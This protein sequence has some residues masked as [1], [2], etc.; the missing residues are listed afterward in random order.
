MVSGQWIVL[1]HFQSR[2]SAPLMNRSVGFA[3]LHIEI[4]KLNNSARDGWFAG[5]CHGDGDGTCRSRSA[6]TATPSASSREQ[7]RLLQIDG[8]GELG[9]DS[10]KSQGGTLR[11]GMAGAALTI[12]VEE[13]FA[14]GDIAGDL[15]NPG[16][17]ALECVVNPLREEMGEVG[18]LGGGQIGAA[19]LTLQRMSLPEKRAEIGT[20]VVFQDY[21]GPDQ[22]GAGFAATG[23]GTMTIHTLSGVQ[24]TSAVGGGRVGHS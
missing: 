10:E 16:G 19:L 23:R 6:A 9:A 11:E 7:H 8:V 15:V 5:R 24:S 20:C 1:N 12:A 14:R 13:S 17:P 18:H 4:V 21:I 3:Q 22:V 2:G